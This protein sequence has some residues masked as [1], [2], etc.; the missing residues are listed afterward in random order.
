[1]LHSVVSNANKA[2]GP[3]SACASPDVF[4]TTHW[5]VVT[6][7][8]QRELPQAAEALECLCRAYWYPLYVF[9]RRQGYNAEDAQDLTQD[10]FSRFLEKNY[11]AMVA[12]ERGK[13]RTFLLRSL[14]NFLINE[15]KRAGRLKRGGVLEFLSID[16]TAAEERYAVEA[17]GEPNPDAEYEESRAVTLTEQVLTAQREEFSAA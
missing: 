13:L 15:W 5:S 8:G 3:P 1:M 6:L 10:F 17:T 16:T 7:A 9:V 4:A 14:K 12:R 11:F 2:A